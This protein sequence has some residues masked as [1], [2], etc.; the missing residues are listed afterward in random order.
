[1]CIGSPT[2]QNNFLEQFLEASAKDVKLTE[3]FAGIYSDLIHRHTHTAH[4]G[5][6]KLTVTAYT[7][8]ADFCFTSQ[9]D[10]S[11]ILFD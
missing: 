1:M 7:T 3:D 8:L 9:R 6:R 4:T 10:N 11:L 2:A 5:T